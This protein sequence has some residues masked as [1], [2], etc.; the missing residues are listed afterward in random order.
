MNHN[1]V[2]GKFQLHWMR[3]TLVCYMHIDLNLFTL[4]M[5]L[6]ESIDAR[7]LLYFVN[8]KFACVHFGIN[9]AYVLEYNSI[10]NFLTNS[11]NRWLLNLTV[12]NIIHL[13][14]CVGWGLE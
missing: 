3:D 2:W 7:D 5:K 14:L 1:L 8:K 11:I 10:V 6:Y 13:T 9:L 12:H 4:R